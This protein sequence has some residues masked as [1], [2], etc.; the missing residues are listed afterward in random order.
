MRSTVVQGMANVSGFA[1]QGNLKSV[2]YTHTPIREIWCVLHKPAYKICMVFSSWKLMYRRTKL[3]VCLD[4]AQ[5]M[6]RTNQFTQSL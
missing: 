4:D 5:V 2:C 1:N 6:P 3:D